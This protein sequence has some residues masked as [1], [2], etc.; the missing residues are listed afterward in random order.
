MESLISHLGCE[1]LAEDARFKT[2]DDRKAHRAELT[3]EL[4][5]WLAG[6]SA[7]QSERE[8]T[9]LGVPVGVVMSS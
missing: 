2:R 5:I 9:S 8:L 7:A 3:G 4:E 6:K 1:H